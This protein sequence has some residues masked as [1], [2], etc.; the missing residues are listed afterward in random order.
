VAVDYRLIVLGR[1]TALDRPKHRGGG[2]TQLHFPTPTRQGQRLGGQFSDLQNAFAGQRAQLAATAEGAQPER[3]LVLEIA[4]TVDEF[5][6]AV[7]RVKGLEWL[8]EWDVDELAADDDF[9]READREHALSGRLFL[10]MS[11]QVAMEQLIRLWRQYQRDPEA[12][13]AHGL[14][15][16]KQ[17]F[18]QLRSIRPWGPNDRLVEAGALTS[19]RDQ[20]ALGP[21]TV[22]FEADLWFRSE[23]TTRSEAR[24]RFERDV[25]QANG[26]V[27]SETVI[28]E[29]A[30]HGVLAEVPSPSIEELTAGRGY[31][32]WV[33]CNDVMVFSAVGQSL[34]EL[35]DREPLGRSPDRGGAAPAGAPTVALLDGLP[36][37][38]HQLLAGRLTVDDPDA[39]AATYPARSRIH[40]TS[41]ASLIIHGDLGRPE[42]PLA[43]P[44][45]ARPVMEP[46]PGWMGRRGER[47]LETR[48]PVDLIHRAIRR[49]F[50]PDDGGPAAPSVRI[51]NLALGDPGR[52]FD[53]SLSPWARL[54]DWLAYRYR[55]LVIISA[56]NHGDMSCRERS[57]DLLAGTPAETEAFVLQSVEGDAR[58]RRLLS[59]A[60]SIN[61]VTVGAA[62]LDHA[63]VPAGGLSF[64]PYV[65]QGMPSPISALGL[66][67]RRSIKPDLLFPGGRQ[68]LIRPPRGIGPPTPIQIARSDI[69]P[70][71]AL[72]ALP[73]NTAGDVTA[74]GYLKGTSVA[75]ALASRCSAQLVDALERLRLETDAA[76]LDPQLDAVLAK[77]LLVHSASWGTAI[78][79]LRAALLAPANASNFREHAARYLGYG[80]AVPE[81]VMSCTE[82]R[83]TLIRSDWLGPDESHLYD[84]PL[85]PSLI[86]RAEW[87]RLT[88]TLAW[89]SPINPGSR[90]YRRAA[91]SFTR[92]NNPDPL[93]V[94]RT[95]VDARAVGRGTVQHEILEGS[96]ASAYVDGDRLRIRIDCR[97]DAGGL[98]ELVPYALAVTLEVRE[99]VDLPI[100]EEIRA[101]VRPTVTIRP[102]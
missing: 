15:R 63:A 55:L 2:G 58:L 42:A 7:R 1:P 68:L 19:W 48:L 44:I 46:L 85:P 84:V 17:I 36:L 97:E 67:Y 64:D 47:M 66:G 39:V 101:R 37:E 22:R 5:A 88:L 80:L 51:V 13:F 34:I 3:V 43:R 60:E 91:L 14:G 94:D 56:G 100:Y 50:E 31:A 18:S 28:T 9:Y 54:L 53:R 73:G 10:L 87:R 82:R 75:A 93:G 79:S 92:I 40:G 32:A 69:Q 89:L 24:E 61:S 27:L 65:T 4:G 95:E 45:Y 57:D 96:Q 86:G 26:R 62:H 90:A 77:A 98:D 83:A 8:A 52:I 12:K 6:N 70:P 41:M 49:L 20:L 81:R 21:Q 71:G 78:N 23:A 59:P 99:G 102:E 74:V 25:A 16:F 72:A 76:G 11:N 35:P 38:N 30:Y 33:S 29:I